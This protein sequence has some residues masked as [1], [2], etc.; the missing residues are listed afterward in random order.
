MIIAVTSLLVVAMVITGVL[1]G[2]KFH[3]DS[4]KEIF[5][6]SYILLIMFVSCYFAAIARQRSAEQVAN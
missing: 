3:L 5:T 1:V 2:V 4:S 6:V